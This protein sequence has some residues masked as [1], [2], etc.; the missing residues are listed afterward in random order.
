MKKRTKGIII[1]L[2]CLVLVVL[3]ATMLSDN[4][5]GEISLKPGGYVE[6]RLAGEMDAKELL[7]LLAKSGINLRDTGETADTIQFQK[8]Q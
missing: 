8:K 1:F 6:A 2:I 4:G 3:V 7:R 5:A